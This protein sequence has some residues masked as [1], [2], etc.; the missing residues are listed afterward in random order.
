MMWSIHA[1]EEE[2]F[3]FTECQSLM[4]IKPN[5]YC[6]KKGMAS[7]FAGIQNPLFFKNNTRMLFG[8]AK[9]SV[10]GLASELKHR[11]Y[12]WPI[13]LNT[14]ATGSLGCNCSIIY[15]EESKEAIIVDLGDD[16]ALIMSKINSLGLKVKLL[17]HTHAHFDH[18]TAQKRLKK[19]RAQK[20]VC[21][22]VISF[23][24]NHFLF[25]ARCSAFLLRRR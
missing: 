24:T 23:C 3:L 18:I 6:S 10:Q 25:S 15:S 4:W 14:F 20:F 5:R 13:K 17:L 19:K 22:R 12:I 9:S 21:T 2:S 16:E 7:G 8:D 11:G 1:R